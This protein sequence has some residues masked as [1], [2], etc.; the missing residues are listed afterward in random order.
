MDRGPLRFTLF[1]HKAVVLVEVGKHAIRVQANGP[2]V[3]GERLFITLEVI[4]N[5]ALI[6][7]SDGVIGV[8][9]N[10]P[11][12]SGERLF[13][14]AETLEGISLMEIGYCIMRILAH[15]S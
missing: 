10:G 12:V 2:L 6:V 8:Q 14:A 9:A 1:P 13:V 11:L 7:V 5:P 15:S 4:K 3:S